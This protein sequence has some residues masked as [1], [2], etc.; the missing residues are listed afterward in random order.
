M[1]IYKVRKNPS[2]WRKR[3]TRL[4]VKQGRMLS[5]FNPNSEDCKCLSELL[6]PSN[7]NTE[8]KIKLNKA[9]LK[10]SAIR[11]SSS[12]KVLY[13][14][15]DL[16]SP[17]HSTVLLIIDRIL[18]SIFFINSFYPLRTRTV[19]VIKAVLQLLIYKVILTLW[20]GF[21]KWWKYK[22]LIKYFNVFHHSK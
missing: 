11:R 6:L 13:N 19:T 16:I 4:C 15:L 12:V 9:I 22:I 18:S 17:A 3:S 7:L 10:R 1:I 21:F 14:Y 8:M 2:L 5:Y 20:R